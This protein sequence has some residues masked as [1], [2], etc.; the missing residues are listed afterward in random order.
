MV[1]QQLS[2]VFFLPLVLRRGQLER[3]RKIWDVIH[4]NL[5][6]LQREN[7]RLWAF[8]YSL[9]FPKWQTNHGQFLP[10]KAIITFQVCFDEPHKIVVQRHDWIRQSLLAITD[11][12]HLANFCGKWLDLR[13][14]WP[15]LMVNWLPSILAWLASLQVALGEKI[16]RFPRLECICLYLSLWLNFRFS[17]K[18]DGSDDGGDIEGEREGRAKLENSSHLFRK[19]IFGRNCFERLVWTRGVMAI[20]SGGCLSITDGRRDDLSKLY[21]QPVFFQCSK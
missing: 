8:D 11:H 19:S 21:R 16:S 7:V 10:R 17:H 1:F 6:V 20:F 15:C 2:V 9:L 3:T 18:R 5:R 12:Y 14:D 4:H 13:S